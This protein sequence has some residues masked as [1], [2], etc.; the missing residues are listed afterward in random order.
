[1]TAVVGILNKQAVAIAADSAVT[2][3][4]RKIFNKAN[5][6][7]TLSK[8]HPVGV[9]IHNDADFMGTPWETIIKIYR[10]QLRDKSFDTLTEYQQDFIDFL[11][12]Q[13]LFCNTDQQMY[14]LNL[15]F[16]SINTY[17]I[18]EVNGIVPTNDV[19]RT[20]KFLSHLKHFAKVYAARF[21]AYTD[22]IPD[23]ATYT[24][25]EFE[26]D[27]G[28]DIDV[29]FDVSFTSQGL[30]IDDEAKALLK[31][32][33]FNQL[34]V[35]EFYTSQ[36][37]GLVF[38]GFGEKEIFPSLIPLQ[39]YLGYSNKLRYYV[40]SERGA[41]ITHDSTSAICMFAQS[42]VMFT[43]LTGVAPDLRDTYNL[44][45]EKF[46][47]TYD[48]V[49]KN[50]YPG[51]D[52]GDLLLLLNKIDKGKILDTFRNAMSDVIQKKYIDPL[53]GAV[54]ALSKE[55][56]GEMAESLIYLTYLQRRI[57]NA[58]ESVGGPVDVALLSKGDGFIWIKRKHYFKPE[59]NMNFFKNYFT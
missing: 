30:P 33:Y 16:I 48:N 29:V 36:F 24:F 41:N 51:V 57:T 7:F 2:I 20:T 56:L 6:I 14:A 40:N 38:S 59:L 49:L 31:Q 47:T 45:F 34:I 12:K 18:N 52:K 13:N 37:T 5:K 23:F 54:A 15:F 43:I 11:K 32:A 26:K 4:N 9:M 44:N 55:D 58:E 42:D 39:I 53:F 3:H 46:M 22:K 1:M 25:T 50:N 27:T 10:Q 8:Y 17:L 19:D 21:A 28:K 35:K